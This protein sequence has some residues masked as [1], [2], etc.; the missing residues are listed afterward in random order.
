MLRWAPAGG[1]RA[2]PAA[3]A[4]VFVDE[5]EDWEQNAINGQGG[6]PRILLSDVKKDKP[7]MFKLQTKY[8]GCSFW[9]KTRTA[10]L[11]GPTERLPQKRS[12]NIAR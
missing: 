4:A 10:R 6:G 2:A 11:A 3:D 1:Q 7:A 12:G 9:T 5:I 8:K